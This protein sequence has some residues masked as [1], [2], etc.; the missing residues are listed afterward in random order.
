MPVTFLLFYMNFT[1]KVLRTTID[2][3]WANK[4]TQGD[5]LIITKAPSPFCTN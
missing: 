3:S 5:L 2:K 4:S 1:V